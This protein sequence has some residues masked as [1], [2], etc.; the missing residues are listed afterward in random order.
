MLAVIKNIIKIYFAYVHLV[1]SFIFLINFVIIFF[2]LQKRRKEL[3][4]SAVNDG[5]ILAKSSLNINLLPETEEDRNMAAL[6]ALRP[7][8]TI[9]EKQS[10]VRSKIINSP[11][12]PSSKGLLTSFGG[13]KKEESLSKAA[14][15]T[16]N[17]LGIAI[18][19]SKPN[20]KSDCS[21]T[22]HIENEKEE[23]VS[24]D[25]LNN[26]TESETKKN[27]NKVTLV[28]D[29]SSSGENSD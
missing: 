3:E 27:E 14:P 5:L 22:K 2:F 26:G 23:L 15:L 8:R 17:S 29:Y 11:A 20:E 7:S 10:A 25:K 13:L 21:E 18:K 4:E 24:K 16:R 12:L 28:C 1:H 9:E 6:L 19:R